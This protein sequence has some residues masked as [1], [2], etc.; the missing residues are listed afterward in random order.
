V[1]PTPPSEDVRLSI[2]YVQS[3]EVQ[4]IEL[5]YD[6]GSFASVI[7]IN[8]GEDV[9]IHVYG[10]GLAFEA[11]IVHL[12]E[13]EGT[14]PN[15][16]E[17]ISPVIELRAQKAIDE[18]AFELKDVQFETNK[19]E[20]TYTTRLILKAFTEY[21]LL[22]EK[23]SISI[24]GHADNIGS[25]KANLKLSRDRAESVL[26][27]FV[28]FGVDASRLEANGYGESNPKASNNDEAGRAVNRRTEFRVYH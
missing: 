13:R 26:Q 16:V 10:D 1:N 11:E 8:R 12:A 27:Y 25:A 23:Y 17:D 9:I 14:V 4:E 21:L 5:N 3:R 6:D 7:N 20:I 18:D 2:E 28:E 19:S 24:T 22:H 15:K